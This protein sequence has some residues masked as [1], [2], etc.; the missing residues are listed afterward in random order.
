MALGTADVP[1][2]EMGA[3]VS[4]GEILLKYTLLPSSNRRK[5]LFFWLKRKIKLFFESAI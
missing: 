2:E 4:N 5:S 1:D 3:Y